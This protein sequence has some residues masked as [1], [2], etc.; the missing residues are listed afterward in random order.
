MTSM[1]Y[2]KF[3]VP[4]FLGYFLVACNGTE[5]TTGSSNTSE[6][7]ESLT[8][9]VSSKITHEDGWAIVSKVESADRVYWFF[10]PDIDDVSPAMFKKT[11][12]NK[13]N[14]GQGFEVVSRCEAP[15]QVCDDL[16]EQFKVL[17][18]KYK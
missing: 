13:D 9:G 14:S 11:I 5:S 8:K 6:T 10:A 1:K 3:I 7:Y 18:E 15:K 16:M 17:S 2:L 4:F 12:L